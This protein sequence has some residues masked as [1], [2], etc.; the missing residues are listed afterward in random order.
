MQ[1]IIIDGYNVIH[2]DPELRRSLDRD[3]E[4]ARDALLERLREYVLRRQVRATVVF[5]GR[6]GLIDVSAAVPGRL[7]VVYTPTGQSA[8]DFIVETVLAARASSYIVVTSDMADIG[9]RLRSQGAQIMPSDRFLERLRRASPQIAPDAA[10][11]EADEAGPGD[12][13][14]WMEQFGLSDKTDE[15]NE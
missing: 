9:R 4:A 5:D 1:R 13:D 11:D 7:Q 12:V 6:G 10:T 3:V 14:Y 8:D 2:A 15:D